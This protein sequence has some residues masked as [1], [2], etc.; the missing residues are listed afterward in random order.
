M[1]I[2][3]I[4]YGNMGKLIEIKATAREHQVVTVVE[5]FA[6]AST[7]DNPLGSAAFYRSISEAAT[8]GAFAGVDLAFDFSSPEAVVRNIKAL[9]ELKIPTVVGTT[10]WEASLEDV[11][12]AVTAADSSLIWASNFSMGVNIFYRIA[13]YAAIFFDSIPEYD[14]G[15]YEI[16]HNKKADSP[17]GTAKTLMDEVLSIM[18]R[19]WDS[20]YD[21]ATGPMNSDT[22]HFA[23]LR[24]GSVP[25]THT[26]IFDS[27]ADTIEIT[28]T[29]RNREGFASGAIRAGEWLVNCPGPG[30]SAGEVRKGIFAFKD[31]LDEILDTEIDDEDDDDDDED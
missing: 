4:G 18:T 20:Q 10:G 1:N 31:V 13:T 17:S 28:H 9:A 3:L 25:G 16:H 7:G 27:P 5:P 23:S 11:T 30:M 14:V 2:A 6:Q 15:G 21:R 24:V 12:Q 22:V 29:A 19:K 26:L 8:A